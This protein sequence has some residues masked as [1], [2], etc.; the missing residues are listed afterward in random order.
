MLPEG[1]EVRNNRLVYDD[2]RNQLAEFAVELRGKVGS[3][4]FAW[5]EVIT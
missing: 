4:N 3:T 5:L 1:F 2:D